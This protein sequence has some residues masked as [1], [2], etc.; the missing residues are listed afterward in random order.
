MAVPV[1]LNAASGITVSLGSSHDAAVLANPTNG[2]FANL[3][4]T[5]S[6]ANVINAPTATSTE[7]HVSAWR[8]AAAD[9]AALTETRTGAGAAAPVPFSSRRAILKSREAQRM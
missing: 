2:P 4:I 1:Y 6:L 5:A 3:N 9:R 7:F 8:V